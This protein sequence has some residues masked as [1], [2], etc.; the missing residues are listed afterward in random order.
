M[1]EDKQPFWSSIPGI[2]TGIAAL[3]TAATGLIAAFHG[4]SKPEDKRQTAPPAVVQP[5]APAPADADANGVAGFWS[6]SAEGLK[7][8][9]LNLMGSGT[10]LHGTYQRPCVSPRIFDIDAA[11]WQGNDLVVTISQLGIDKKTHSPAPPV[12]FDLQLKDGKLSGTYTRLKRQVPITLTSGRQDC[13][14]GV[15]EQ[16]SGS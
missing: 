14:A 1:A 13:P 15:T 10:I 5:A 11:S 16:D 7:M 2:L 9:V 8:G 6:G 3:V 4:H 12:Q